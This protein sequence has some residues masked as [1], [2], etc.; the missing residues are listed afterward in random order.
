[1]VKFIFETAIDRSESEI[2]F[3]KVRLREITVLKALICKSWAPY[4]TAP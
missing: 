1:M 2:I 4:G 3:A